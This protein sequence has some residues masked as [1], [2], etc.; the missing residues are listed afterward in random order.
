MGRPVPELETSAL[1]PTHMLGAMRAYV[2]EAL[3]SRPVA[4]SISVE[5]L[6]RRLLRYQV[7]FDQPHP[8]WPV[9]GKVYETPEAGQ[10]S[11]DGMRRLW[12]AG[13][14]SQSPANIRI[15]QPYG[16]I[17]HLRMLL[18]QEVPGTAL[19]TLVKR[20]RATSGDMRLYG[21][22]LAKLHRS[23]AVPKVAYRVEDHLAIRCAG[24]HESL[25]GAFPDIAFQV[26][27]LAARAREIETQA[28][29]RL[30]A[31]HGDFHLGQVHIA[32]GDAWILDLDPLHFGD[33][34]YD[35]AM[36]FVMLKHLDRK[37]GDPAYIQML[38]DAF[39]DA[40]LTQNG[41][42]AFGRVPM[43]AALIHLKRACKR[44]RYQDEAG[45]QDT[46]RLQIAEGVTCMDRMA[47]TT[48]LRSAGDVAA[49]YDACP[50]TV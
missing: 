32:D 48:D 28:D 37:M 49:L 20:K 3:K 12:D 47:S 40:Y 31:V 19:K 14:S 21:E 5:P 45:W 26:R 29:A 9:I 44:F 7:E 16:Y 25:A 41:S 6:E 39:I 15:P 4:R 46:I 18:M 38:R 27:S 17:S 30:T 35:V 43:H 50:A 10:R 1:D 13:F 23:G 33:P 22:A 8:K 24:L 2:R 34:A 36:V 42:D 11:F